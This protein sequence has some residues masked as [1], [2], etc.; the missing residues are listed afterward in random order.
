M[1]GWWD[2]HVVPRLIC[3]ACAQ[4]QVMK[5]RSKIVPFA[6]GRVC[7]IGCGGG[8]NFGFYDADRVTSLSGIDPSPELL[9]ASHEAAHPL[10]FA[11]DL[12]EGVGEALPFDAAAFDTVVT[13]FT[14]CSVADPTA[15]LR[16]IRRVLKPGGTALFIEHGGAPDPSVAQWQRRIEPVWKRIAGGC[17]LTR[18]IS[19]SYAA[20]GFAVERDGAHY[21]PDTPRFAGWVEY[22]AAR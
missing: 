17:H 10:P 20:A 13:T 1:I 22:G 4:G 9:N 14:L 8:I 6:Q 7:E 16:E 5:L 3:C 21:M 12:R 19:A 15:V 11:T 2:R 18:P